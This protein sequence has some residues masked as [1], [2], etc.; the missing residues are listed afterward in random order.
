MTNQNVDA[1]VDFELVDAF[2]NPWDV[3]GADD[4]AVIAKK[5]GE[6]VNACF[7]QYGPAQ[8]GRMINHL[9]ARCYASCNTSF[10]TRGDCGGYPYGISA[11]FSE[12]KSFNWSTP[13]K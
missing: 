2:T 10:P 12:S 1:S 7:K 8:Q 3:G 13:C 5:N 11:K 4:D 6:C 9:F